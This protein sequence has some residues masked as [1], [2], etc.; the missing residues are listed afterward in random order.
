MKKLFSRNV[1]KMQNGGVSDLPETLP[2]NVAQTSQ[3]CKQSAKAYRPTMKN[4]K[5]SC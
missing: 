1:V 5:K 2:Q 4:G 3:C